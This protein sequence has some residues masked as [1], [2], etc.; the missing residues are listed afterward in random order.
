ME[1]WGA[2]SKNKTISTE[3]GVVKVAMPKVMTSAQATTP[4]MTL[5][6]TIHNSTQEVY[7][8]V[9]QRLE[10]QSSQIWKLKV[11]MPPSKNKWKSWNSMSPDWA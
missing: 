1:L 8:A 4:P 3:N 6:F 5:A 11:Q 7:Q 2:V 9:A 10:W